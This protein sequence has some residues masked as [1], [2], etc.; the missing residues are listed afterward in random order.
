MSDQDMVMPD[1]RP[2]GLRSVSGGEP[3]KAP[4]VRR[5]I[6]LIAGFLALLSCLLGVDQVVRSGYFTIEKVQITSEL[7]VADRALLERSSWRKISGN[8]L[9]V[10]L[11]EIETALE[12]LPGVYQAVVRRVWPDALAIEVIETRAMAQYQEWSESSAIGTRQFI[13]LPP[14]EVL[15]ESPLLIGPGAYR[16]TLVNTFI[17]TFPLLRA[18]DLEPKTLSVSPSGRW[19]LELALSGAPKANGFSVLL[20]RDDIRAKVERFTGSY[21]AVLKSKVNL[22]AKVDMRYANGFAVQWR[23]GLDQN[24]YQLAAM[25]KN[26]N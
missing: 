1:L 3:G 16:D 12:A 9:N 6:P 20:G 5:T 19:V 2:A 10:D 21:A 13:N 23:E 14:D 22:I 24:T 17:E 26:E 4:I 11:K 15:Q 7:E 8:Y 18:V 25:V